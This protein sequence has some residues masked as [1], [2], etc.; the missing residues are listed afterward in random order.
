MS[1][2]QLL[3]AGVATNGDIP[4]ADA[5][6]M[7]VGVVSTYPPRIC[8]IGTFSRDL[9]EALLGDDGV[10]AVDLA[11]IVRDDDVEAAGEVVARIHQDQ[12]GDYAAAAR[13]LERRG[14]DVV[15]IQHEYGI[16][17]GPEGAHILSLAEGLRQPMVLTLHT[18]LSAPSVRQAETLRALCDLATLVCVFTETARRMILDAHLAAP[19]RVRVVPHGGPPELLPDSRTPRRDRRVLATFGLI[20]PGKGIEVAIAAMPAIVASH[21]DALYVIAGQTHPEVAKRHGEEYR[22]SLERLARDL[23]LSEHVVFDD[24][25]LGLDDLSSMLA[26]TSIYLTPYRSREQIVSGALTFA[27][28]A[29]CPTVSTPYYYAEDLLASGAG[30]IV[31][32]DDPAALADAVVGLLDDPQRLERT[33]AEARAVGAELAWPQVGRETAAVLCEAVALGPPKSAR[34]T[35]LATLPRARVSHLLTMVDDVGI[36]QHADGSVP[37]RASGYCTDDVARLAIVAL[38]LAQTTGGE[39]HQRILAR[40]L[41]FLRHAWSPQARGMRNFMSYDRRWLD[42][43]HSGDHLGRASWALG[44]V[45]AANPGVALLGPSVDLLRE[46]LPARRELHW[47]RSM[48]FAVLGLARA[49]GERLGPEATDVLRSLARELADRQR[50]NATPDWYW[51]E[52]ALTYDNARMPQALIAAGARLGDEELVQEGL[53]ALTWYARE[54]QIEGASVRLVGHHGHRRDEPRADT[55]DEQPLDA[56]ALVEAE[57]EAFAVTG[58]QSRARDAVRAFECFLGRNWLGLPVYDFSTGGCHDGLGASGVNANEGAESTLAYLQAL[59]ALD[60]AGLQATL[61]G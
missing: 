43:P 53:R 49:G 45:V 31:G 10:R 40:S 26:D 47:P 36:V 24:R 27:I 46:M 15:V 58:E 25:F 59:L 39:I 13:M 57:V 20:S 22:L 50:A 60:A 1:V 7:R 18:V 44:E 30:V 16:F 17:G 8:G 21:P 4:A 56:A 12:R 48:A 28:V 29:G 61:P 5:K 32:F 38:G 3:P 52:N 14:D 33:R 23:D 42:S 34:H 11:A 55:G 6:T 37:Q 19:E 9:R 35:R 54:L 41:A 51:V 2:G